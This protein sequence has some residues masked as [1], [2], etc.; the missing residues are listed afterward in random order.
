MAKI[1]WVKTGDGDLPTMRNRFSPRV[2]F[3][4]D[5]GLL[6]LIIAGIIQLIEVAVWVAKHVSVGVQG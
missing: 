3:W 2:C 4:L 6:V 5:V 1:P